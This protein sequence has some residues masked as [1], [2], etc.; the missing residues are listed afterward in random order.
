M[1]T[2]WGVGEFPPSDY[3]LV[4]AQFGIAG[5]EVA[6]HWPLTYNIANLHNPK[7]GGDKVAFINEAFN[8][9]KTLPRLK[10]AIYW[11]ERWQDETGYFANLHVNSTPESLEA[12]RKGVAD[13]IWLDHP[14]YAPKK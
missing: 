9:M 8:V 12:Y 4:Y 6:G 10:A 1:L 13:P 3:A 7:S 14:I 2:E 11:N 5:L